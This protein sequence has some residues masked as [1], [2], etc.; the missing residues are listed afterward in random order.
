MFVVNSTGDSATTAG[1]LR[2]ALTNAQD[3]DI[4][5]FSAAYTIA[6]ESALPQITKSITIEGN[7]ST[8]TRASSWTETSTTSQLL[9]VSST[10][11]TVNISRIHFKDGR[12]TGTFSSGAAIYNTGV[13][14]L[15]S[16]IFSGN[17]SV[18]G[19]AVYNNRTMYLR[20]CTFYNN[21]SSRGGAVFIEN[22]SSTLTLAGNVFYGNTASYAGSVV[23]EYSGTVTSL[24]YNV[25]DVT[26][27]TGDSK[28]G[29]ESVTGDTTFSDLSITGD[30]FDTTTFAPADGLKNVM[31]ST[32]ITGFPATDFNG[33]TRDWPGAPGAVK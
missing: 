2:Y 14:T 25:V 1:T 21:T 8:I 12:V 4:I 3:G 9:R 27:G 7:G 24:G 32:A 11:V 28:S 20:G 22:N 31:P 23:Y 33:V 17:S 13:L 15:E 16:C 19:G 18:Y 10:T 6:L 5:R 30:P 29:W 26:L